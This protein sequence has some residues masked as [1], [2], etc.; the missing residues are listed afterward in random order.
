MLLKKFV[1][2]IKG[3]IKKKTLEQYEKDKKEKKMQIV[4]AEECPH[5]FSVDPSTQ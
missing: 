5:D 1:V 2:K 4:L 3:I